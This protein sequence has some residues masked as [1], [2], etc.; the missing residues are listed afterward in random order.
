MI[1]LIQGNLFHGLPNKDPYAHLA[2]YIEICNTSKIAGVLE[3]AIRLNLFSFSLAGEAKRWLHSFKGNSLKTWEEVV[4]IFLQK[5]F[6]ES[7]TTKGKAEISS[8][9]EFSDESL[10]EAVERFRGLLRRTPTNGFTEPI[11]LNIFIDGLRPQS[12]QLLDASVGGK[13]QIEDS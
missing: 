10:S 3:D 1:Q 9:H 13:N 2:I 11:Q 7:K 6:P 4:E 8:F 5:Y 12:K